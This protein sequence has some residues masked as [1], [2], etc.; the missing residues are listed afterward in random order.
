MKPSIPSLSRRVL[1]TLIAFALFSLFPNVLLSDDA[2]SE[3]PI[4]FLQDDQPSRLSSRVFNREP[5]IS[6]AE[7]ARLSHS[8][9]RWMGVTKQACLTNARGSMCFNWETEI[10]DYNASRLRKK[11]SVSLLDNHVYVPMGF[12]ES[13]EFQAFSNSRIEWDPRNNRLVQN[14]VVTLELPPIE[15]D[16]G[17]YRL[18]L[19]VAKTVQYQLLENNDKRI[20]LRFLGAQAGGSA[21]HEGDSVIKQIR[22]LQRRK[23]ADVL[24]SL[25]AASRS[26]NVYFD[27][28]QNSL[29]VE[30]GSDGQG[31]AERAVAK[32]PAAPAPAPAPPVVRKEKKYT[33]VNDD[34]IHTIVIDAGHGGKDSGALG[35][36]GT[37][38]KDINLKFAKALADRLRQEKNL[39]VI[40]TRDSDEFIPLSDRT[41]IAND[42]K[43]DMFVSIHCNSSL[44]KES[45]GFE[46]YLLSPEATD[47]AAEGVARVENSVVALEA[48]KGAKSSKL[49]ELLASMAVS[50]FINDSSEFAALLLRGVQKSSSMKLISVK[51][52]NFY[53]L[54]GAQMPG[55][56]V[57]LDYLSNPGMELKLR[58][59]RYRGQLV[60]GLVDG[61]LGYDK[62]LRGR[63]QALALTV[64]E[65][66]KAEK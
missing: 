19:P 2:G 30:I 65:K 5:S 51:E 37:Q 39:R 35:Y 59:A 15:N 40:L 36:R 23:S 54:R 49:G 31:V 8:Q 61:I 46:V 22:V 45:K 43:A 42:A 26:H 13:K 41:L 66:S 38:E 28:K 55:V 11:Y 4:E 34:R 33:P 6:V 18:Q 25:G 7:L 48:N 12:L 14:A 32:E 10:I 20:W 9:L 62:R 21:I 53:V 52:A 29:M 63:K 24:I 17:V 16:N 57:E 44:S 64:G 3:I 47:E 60:K 58:S 56:I 27:K 1:P 50:N